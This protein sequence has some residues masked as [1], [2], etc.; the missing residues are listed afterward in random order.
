MKKTILLC[1]SIASGLLESRAQID[2]GLFRYPDVS[3]TQIVFSYANDLWLVSRSGGA[4]YKISSP[5]GVESSPKFSPDG[6]I[7]AFTGNYDGNR[8]VYT[9]NVQGG[10]PKRLTEHGY[11]DRVV[12]WTPDGRNILFASAR[13]SGKERFNQFYSI[14][15]SGGAA[16]KLPLAYAEFGSYSPDGGQMAVTFRTQGREGTGRDTAADGRRIFIFSI[17]RPSS[18]KIYLRWRKPGMNIPCGA[19]KTFIFYQTGA[20]IFG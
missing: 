14:P 4:A 5:P 13:E 2:A 17:L 16:G 20:R 8:D 15:F 7:I 19:E 11:T 6:K 18:L 9:M 10:I 1:F 3:E 12:D